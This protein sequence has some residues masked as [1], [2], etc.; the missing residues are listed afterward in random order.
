MTV[1]GPDH[2]ITAADASI[3]TDASKLGFGAFFNGRWFNGS[4]TPTEIAAF[5]AQTVTINEFELLAVVFAISTWAHLLTARRILFYCD[6]SA[7]VASVTTQQSRV[8]VRSALLR[9]LYAIAAIHSIDLKIVWLGTKTNI[10]ADALSRFDIPLFQKITQ[11]RFMLHHENEPAL[12][13]RL[14]LF[15]PA[16]PQNPSSPEW[17]P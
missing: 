13:S 2:W 3:Y 17:R 7:S 6:N 14:L 1:I 4:F 8:P 5:E 16:G 9:H 12:A 11:D 15:D 10:I